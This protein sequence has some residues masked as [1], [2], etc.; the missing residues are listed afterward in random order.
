[1]LAP[2]QRQLE[3]IYE[4]EIPQNVDDFLITDANVLRDLEGSGDVDAPAVD[5]RLLVAQDGDTWTLL[6]I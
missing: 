3:R 2:L 1:M 6:F 5:E 4:I